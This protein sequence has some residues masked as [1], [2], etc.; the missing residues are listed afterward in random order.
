MNL[1]E[2]MQLGNSLLEKHGLDDWKFSISN[3]KRKLGMCSFNSK[4]I[5]FS[6]YF[7]HI[8]DWKIRDTILH[9]IAHALVGGEHG[10]D[11][12]W[13][14][15]CIE[16]GARPQRLAPPDMRTSAKVNYVVK[17]VNPR[18]SQDILTTR[19]RLKKVMHKA[20][21][22]KCRQPVKIFKVVRN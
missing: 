21:C 13:K 9:E 11:D 20:I 2:C 3:H 4:T 10:H 14:A 19:Y 7:L 15:K 6:K 1:I 5:V 8:P 12:V 17:C 18:C 16:V 22:G